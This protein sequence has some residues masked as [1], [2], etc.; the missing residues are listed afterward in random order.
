MAVSG[1]YGSKRVPESLVCQQMSECMYRTM[2]AIKESK[3]IYH[4]FPQGILCK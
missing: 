3:P 1:K 4:S 2:S